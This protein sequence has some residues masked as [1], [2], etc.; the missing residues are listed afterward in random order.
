MAVFDTHKAVKTLTAAGF[1]EEKAE[2][3]ITAMGDARTD[4]TH[5]K[6]DLKDLELRMMRMHIA[7]VVA[8][9]GLVVALLKLLP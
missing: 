2:A 9:V 6:A 3:L 8:T 4:L 1:S 7:S 5:A